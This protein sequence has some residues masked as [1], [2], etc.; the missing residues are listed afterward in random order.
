MTP[1]IGERAQYRPMEPPSGAARVLDH[2]IAYGRPA[3]PPRFR[4]EHEVG[5]PR[6]GAPRALGERPWMAYKW[7]SASA[8]NA[9]TSGRRADSPP[10]PATTRRSTTSARN[11]R[12]AHGGSQAATDLRYWSEGPG[13][14]G[15]PCSRSRSGSTS[16]RC[17]AHSCRHSISPARGACTSLPAAGPPR[18]RSPSRV[19]TRHLAAANARGAAAGKPH[20]RED[21]VRLGQPA[22]PVAVEQREQ[23]MI[24]E[25]HREG[26]HVPALRPRVVLNFSWTHW[27][28]RV[29]SRRG[30]GARRVCHVRAGSRSKRPTSAEMAGNSSPSSA[31]P[32]CGVRVGAGPAPA[33]RRGGARRRARR[34]QPRGAGTRGGTRGADSPRARG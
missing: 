5:P 17:S 25:P 15:S 2:T 18:R 9:A 22:R 29:A 1:K 16:A 6:A 3:D 21:V 33:R 7:R 10:T 34:A 28:K 4:L 8:S 14:T 24:D 26:A 13:H 23:Q 11:I 27:C 31:R 20:H 19:T 30:R 32:P 12:L